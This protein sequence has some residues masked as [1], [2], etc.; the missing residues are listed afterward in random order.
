MLPIRLSP[1]LRTVG[2][3]CGR[4]RVER[5]ERPL[6]QRDALTLTRPVV[7]PTLVV[8]VL[9]ERADTELRP[10]EEREVVRR[11]RERV[12]A[13]ERAHR[14]AFERALV[15]RCGVE[16]P[17]GHRV[18]RNVRRHDAVDAAHQQERSPEPAGVGLVGDHFGY[19]DVGVLGHGLHHAALQLEVVLG[20]HLELL[21]LQRCQPGHVALGRAV[22]R[23]HGEEQRLARHA[24]PLGCGD[25]GDGRAGCHPRRPPRLDALG[26]RRGI[27][28]PWR[29]ESRFFGGH[30]P[31][32]CD[33][34]VGRTVSSCGAAP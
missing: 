34:D 10:V 15:V 7:V 9:V 1:Q 26:H 24:A 29:R 20:E 31:P 30:H 12:Q 32:G 17:S 3:S 14:L 13:R 28:A 6:D 23:L 4:V 25:L 18:R 19:R 16:Q 21:R 5:G 11:R 27:A 22:S 8:E 33:T 2:P